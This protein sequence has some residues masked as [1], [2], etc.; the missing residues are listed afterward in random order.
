MLLL[1]PRSRRMVRL[2]AICVSVKKNGAT[3][4]FAL[5]G[6]VTATLTFV[7]SSVITL[8]VTV[9]WAPEI[10]VASSTNRAASSTFAAVAPGTMPRRQPSYT[11]FS[12]VCRIMFTRENSNAAKVNKK[13]T[14]QQIANSTTVSA[15]AATASFKLSAAYTHGFPWSIL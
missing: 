15:K 5:V 1:S 8:G 11:E 9:T 13:S 7:V 12:T 6:T 4:E 3:Q 14:G 10:N 2:L